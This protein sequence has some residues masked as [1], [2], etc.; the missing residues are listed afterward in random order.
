MGKAV[1][2]FTAAYVKS[3]LRTRTTVGGR[4][5]NGT[6]RDT[7]PRARKTKGNHTISAARD[8]RDLSLRTLGDVFVAFL[9]TDSGKRRQSDMR[10]RKHE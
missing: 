2:C 5:P 1:M 7:Y 10:T 8:G 6:V 9:V 3:Q 4:R